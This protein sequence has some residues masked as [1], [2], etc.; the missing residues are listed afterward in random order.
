MTFTGEWWQRLFC[1][2]LIAT[3]KPWACRHLTSL[4]TLSVISFIQLYIWTKLYTSTKLGWA[5]PAKHLQAIWFHIATEE[6][7]VISIAITP[8]WRNT[9][10]LWLQVQLSEKSQLC[11]WAVL[12][13]SH[14]GTDALTILVTGIYIGQSIPKYAEKRQSSS[15]CE[16]CEKQ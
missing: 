9:F 1:S 13:A 7:Q 10:H 15:V 14:T 12:T 6:M 2:A 4:T 11:L 8:H 3:N 16:M 5:K